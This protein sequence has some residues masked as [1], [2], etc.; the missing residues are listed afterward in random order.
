MFLLSLGLG[1][2]ADDYPQISDWDEASKDFEKIFL[3]KTQEEWCKIFDFTDACVTP[4]IPLEEAH[5]HKHN[6]ENQSFVNDGDMFVPIPAP[7]LSTTPAEVP[8]TKPMPGQ[9]TREVL[10][11][12]GFT[13]SE[14]NLLMR[15]ETVC[16]ASLKSSL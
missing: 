3:C 1:L 9:H 10:L 2:S 13:D 16:T 11:E 8:L 12:A 6:T 14:I 4:V 5:T 7:R 15:D